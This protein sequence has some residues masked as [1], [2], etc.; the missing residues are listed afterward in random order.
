MSVDSPDSIVYRRSN[1]RQVHA[2][3]TPKRVSFHEDVAEPVGGSLIQIR[4]VAQYGERGTPEGQEDPQQPVRETPTERSV[5]KCKEHRRP[6][7]YLNSSFSVSRE[8]LQDISNDI[9]TELEKKQWK[10]SWSKH[11]D[12]GSNCLVNIIK[13]DLTLKPNE[14]IYKV[15]RMLSTGGSP[16][17]VVIT[18]IRFCVLTKNVYTNRLELVYGS[19]LIDL[20]VIVLGPNEQT[21]VFV[22]EKSKKCTLMTAVD[23]RTAQEMIGS[24]EFA[25]RRS[26]LYNKNTAF[27]VINVNHDEKMYETVKTQ[28]SLSK[29]DKVKYYTWLWCYKEIESSATVKPHL[30]EFLMVKQNSLWSPRFVRLRDDILYV[31]NE[32]ADI[33]PLES[34]PLRFGRCKNVQQIN[35][36]RPHSVEIQLVSNSMILATADCHQ[37]EKWINALN[38]ALT[39]IKDCNG[40]TKLPNGR[41]CLLTTNYIVLYNFPHSIT[42]HMQLVNLDSV[43]CSPSPTHYYVILEWACYDATAEEN[44]SDWVVHFTCR[45]SCDEF[46]SWLYRIRPDLTKQELVDQH[47]AQRHSKNNVTLRRS[48]V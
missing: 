3:V 11:V 13:R 48:L 38:R 23:T 10:Y 34:I 39:G 26:G 41:C 1:T 9:K 24:I 32:P 40:T 44:C 16:L 46:I 2:V 33:V 4:T 43:Q 17:I 29:D 42:D 35:C 36:D 22:S 30:E 21:A 45:S 7:L 19:Y 28:V 5:L 25:F 27:V 12:L 14:T 31:F 18:N 15:Y 20:E 47:A 37:E 6:S 8:G